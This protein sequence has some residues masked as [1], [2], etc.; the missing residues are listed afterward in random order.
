[1]RI[2]LPLFAAMLPAPLPVVPAAERAAELHFGEAE[3]FAQLVGGAGQL[4]E[5][6]AAGGFQQIQLS[7]AVRKVSQF[8]AD[9]AHGASAIPIPVEELPHGFEEYLIEVRRF[10]QGP[11]A[12]DGFKAGVADGYGDGRASSP[13]SR[14]RLAAFWQRWLSM[15]SRVARSRVSLSNVWLWES[16]LAS[17]STKNS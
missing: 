13:D 12:R 15:A 6:F 3:A 10:G 5:F 2:L 1:M 11:G 16:D 8:H 9:Q 4:V 17:A 7:A 14:K